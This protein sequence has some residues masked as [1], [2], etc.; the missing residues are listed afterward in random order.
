MK[1]Q[2]ITENSKQ[3]YIDATQFRMSYEELKHILETDFKK[4]E[5]GIQRFKNKKSLYRGIKSGMEI[6]G[7]KEVDLIRPSSYTAN[8]YNVWTSESDPWK[9]F[10]KRNK[11]IIATTRYDK[12]EGYGNVYVVLPE[13]NPTVGVTHASDMWMAFDR[14]SQIDGLAGTFAWFGNLGSMNQFFDDLLDTAGE[15][16][17][18]IKSLD[19]LEMISDVVEQAMKADTRP[20]DESTQWAMFDNYHHQIM[21]LFDYSMISL[22]EWALDPSANGIATAPLSIVPDG[23]GE[24]WLEGDAILVRPDV[25]RKVLADIS[26]DKHTFDSTEVMKLA[27]TQHGLSFGSNLFRVPRKYDSFMEADFMGVGEFFTTSSYPTIDLTS[28]VTRAMLPKN[29]I[30]FDNGDD[31]EYWLQQVERL[32]GF[33]NK[34]ARIEAGYGDIQALIQLLDPDIKGIQV[35]SDRDVLIIKWD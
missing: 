14:V 20:H 12:A 27:Q 6:I 2:H 35:G 4:Y 1:I 3:D 15:M 16:T 10:P 30:R 17:G 26:V 33:K 9:D 32:V 11:S 23:G 28:D 19:D 21:K 25:L 18:S 29:A 34:R 22:M 24:V 8:Y 13:G 31:L 5:A 7:I